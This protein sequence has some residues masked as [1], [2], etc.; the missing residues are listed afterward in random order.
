MP[1]PPKIKAAVSRQ[2]RVDRLAT[3]LQEHGEATCSGIMLDV[4]LEAAATVGIDP[5]D[6]RVGVGIIYIP[7]RPRRPLGRGRP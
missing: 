7:A 5:K 1:E 2:D 4:L 6:L 3:S